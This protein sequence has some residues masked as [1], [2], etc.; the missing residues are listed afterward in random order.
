[1]KRLKKVII[2]AL[3]MLMLV[4]T[5]SVQ[6]ASKG[7]EKKSV[8]IGVKDKVV[9]S[10]KNYGD[11][12]SWSISGGSAKI[13]SKNS[14]SATIKGIKK[15]KST[16]KAKIGKKVYKCTINVK[17]ATDSNSLKKK[18]KITSVKSVDGT[19]ILLK[20]RNTSDYV[21][22]VSGK[23]AFYNSNGNIVGT[24]SFWANPMDKN[25]VITDYAYCDE[26]YSSYEVL[27]ESVDKAWL[28]SYS[29]KI[30]ISSNKSDDTIYITATNNSKKT[31][32]N[33]VK[34]AVIVYDADGNFLDYNWTY[35]DC[36]DAGSS[37]I[38]SCWFYKYRDSIASYDTNIVSAYVYK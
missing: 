34:V 11:V 9:I 26:D 22:A 17:G 30:T 14:Y 25:R 7:L 6:A 32:D 3:I 23:V 19:K 5:T 4:P 21:L 37:A 2:F 35:I 31:L 20:M 27:I 13:T 29:S 36:S 33:K 12:K 16:L 1:M 15:G 38:G 24:S 10:S 18:V 28:K 8:E